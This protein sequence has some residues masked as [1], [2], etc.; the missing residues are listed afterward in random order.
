MRDSDTLYEFI[1]PLPGIIL[2]GFNYHEKLFPRFAAE[3]LEPQQRPPGVPK[4]CF[5]HHHFTLTA[6]ML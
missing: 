6:M 2:S 3:P 5:E 1:H 4:P